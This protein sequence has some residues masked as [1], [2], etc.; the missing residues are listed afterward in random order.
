MTLITV[1][2]AWL[3]GKSIIMNSEKEVVLWTKKIE[4]RK[5]LECRE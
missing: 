4:N 3:A 5:E 2:W 1:E